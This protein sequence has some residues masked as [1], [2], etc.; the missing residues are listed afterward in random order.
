MISWNENTEFKPSI[1]STAKKDFV[2]LEWISLK[3]AYKEAFSL[4]FQVFQV[5]IIIINNIIYIY[6]KVRKETKNAPLLFM[7]LYVS[8]RAI[9]LGSLGITTKQK[10]NDYAI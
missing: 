9:F 6:K 5:I 7:Y 4:L 8:K 2:F 1:P 10:G 3:L